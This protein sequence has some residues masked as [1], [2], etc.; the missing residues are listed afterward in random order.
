MFDFAETARRESEKMKKKA[1]RRKKE[2]ENEKNEGKITNIL[3]K[4]IRFLIFVSTTKESTVVS[5]LNY[6]TFSQAHDS[7]KV[8]DNKIFILNAK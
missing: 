7:M 3:A 1:A 4:S 2:R 6:T 5:R 8:N